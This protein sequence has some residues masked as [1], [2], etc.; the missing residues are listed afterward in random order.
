MEQ[1]WSDTDRGN[2]KNLVKR[3]S[4]WHYVRQKYDVD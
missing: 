2:P 1:R 4:K 3:L